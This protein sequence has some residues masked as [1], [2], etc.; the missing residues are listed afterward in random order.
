ML[1]LR[2]RGRSWWVIKPTRRATALQPRPASK[3]LQ[4]LSSIHLVEIR[5]MALKLIE[6]LTH[7]RAGGQNS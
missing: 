2:S 7:L 4:R 3:V 1:A 5:D 6:I